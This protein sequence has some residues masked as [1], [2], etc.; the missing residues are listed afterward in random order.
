MAVINPL[1][2]RSAVGY[3]SVIIASW[4]MATGDTAAFLEVPSFGDHSVQVA[5]TFGG[6]TVNIEGSNDGTNFVTM[7]DP[8]GTAL[9]F[10][11]AGLKQAMELVRYIRP[12]VVGGS[13]VSITV[14]MVMHKLSSNT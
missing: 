9:A 4:T 14:T 1:V 11:A 8:Q 6:A 13:G 10:S 2:D 12:A 5:G 3:H 7:T